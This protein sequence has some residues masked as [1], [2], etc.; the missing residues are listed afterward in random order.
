MNLKIAPAS[1]QKIRHKGEEINTG[2][3]RRPPNRDEGIQN[4]GHLGNES[5][6]VGKF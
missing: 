2:R 5:C 4:T 1:C 3:A 6:R